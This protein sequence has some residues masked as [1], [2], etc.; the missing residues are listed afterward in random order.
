MQ[1]SYSAKLFLGI[2]AALTLA[3]VIVGTMLVR[4]P[5]EMKLVKMDQRR[6]Q[7][8]QQLAQSVRVFYRAEK[9]LP[10]D[11]LALKER[12]DRL[13]LSVDPVTGRSYQ[14][15]LI[16]ETSFELCATFSLS[17][18]EGDRPMYG[19]I[20]DVDWRHPAGDYCYK[21]DIDSQNDLRGF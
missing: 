7:H 20:Y 4:S 12:D 19:L 17:T 14:Y 13:K 1:P 5:A 15:N 9:A 16:G 21:I 11:L 8:L 10:Q 3:L 2:A 18:L 6:A